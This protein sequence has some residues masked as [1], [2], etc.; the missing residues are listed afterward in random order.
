MSNKQL[1]ILDK[2]WYE[3]RNERTAQGIREMFK[4]WNRGFHANLKVKLTR[5]DEK[6]KVPR[7]GYKQGKKRIS[8]ACP[9][10]VKN[11]KK[12]GFYLIYI[13]FM[14]ICGKV[15]SRLLK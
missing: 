9:Q 12:M 11:E 14:L 5:T 13:V 4:M 6:R 10:K 1:L 7:T 8:T 2:R 15:P 3:T